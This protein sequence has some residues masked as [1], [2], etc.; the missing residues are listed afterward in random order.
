MKLLIQP[1][2]SV[3]PLI[4]AIEKAKK[5]VEII[6][7]RFDRL[8]IERALKDAAKR[9]VFVHA[10]IAYTNRGGEKN[11]RKLEMRFL[12]AGITVARTADDLVRYHGKMMVIDRKQLYLLAFNF[13]HLD[14]ERSRSF[15]IVTSRPRLVQEA[16]KL[17]E[18]DTKRQAYNPGYSRFLVSPLNA[19]KELAKFLKE[20]RKELLIYDLKVTDRAMLKILEDRADA[21]V[22]I[23]LIGNTVGKGSFLELRKLNGLRQHT[24][25]IIR[26]GR[27]M[28]IGSQSLRSLELDDRREIGIIVNDPK[29]IRGVKKVFE[30]DWKAAAPKKGSEDDTVTPSVAKAAKKVA[31][32][33]AQNLPPVGPVVEKV[34]KEVTSNTIDV[35]LDHKEVDEAVKGA[36]K[37]AVKEALREVMEEAADRSDPPGK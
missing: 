35:E 11:L 33:I 14:I 12:A 37:D 36:V 8:E 21:G 34:I 15:A 19:R 16:A 23:R 4:K 6:I 3:G 24:R 31:K 25:T 17:F 5:S 22:K 20:A 30:E 18:A 32:N 7:F 13:T 27:E 2:D 9:G 26:D 28:F 29:I 10:L 1:G